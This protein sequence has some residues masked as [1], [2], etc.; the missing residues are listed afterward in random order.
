MIPVMILHIV[1]LQYSLTRKIENRLINLIQKNHKKP[2]KILP[3]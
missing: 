1:S 3:L 2:L